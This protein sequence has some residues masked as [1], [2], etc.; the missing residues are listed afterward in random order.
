MGRGGTGTPCTGDGGPLGEADPVRLPATAPL[1]RVLEGEPV[2]VRDALAPEVALL[3]RDALA[4]E[5]RLLLPVA[6]RELDAGFEGEL[7]RLPSLSFSTVSTLVVALELGLVVDGWLAAPVEDVLTLGVALLT[8]LVLTLGVA[9]AALMLVV[10]TLGVALLALLVLLVL[11]V[12]APGVALAV[13]VVEGPGLR[14][15]VAEVVLEAEGDA[16]PPPATSLTPERDARGD[17]EDVALADTA[18]VLVR[19]ALGVGG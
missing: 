3:E 7:V 5:V 4:P 11:L 8:L 17:R 14:G 6:V 12:L 15:T 2:P 16:G 9:L 18:L 10:L 13:L 19:V 1:L